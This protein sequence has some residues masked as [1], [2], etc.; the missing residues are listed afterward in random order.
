MAHITKGYPLGETTTLLASAGVSLGLALAGV[1]VARTSMPVPTRSAYR[2]AWRLK[3]LLI[4]NYYQDEYQV[5][6]ANSVVRPISRGA[7]KFDQGV[8]D[9]VVNGISSVSLFSGSRIRRIQSGVVS[10]YATLLTLGLVLMLA[11]FGIMGGCF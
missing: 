3:T 2:Q 5:W 7:D 11:A 4:H 1:L 8:V 6:L 9:G 10:N